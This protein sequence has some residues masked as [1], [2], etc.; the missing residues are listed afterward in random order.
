MKTYHKDLYATASITD[1]ADGTARLVV[2]TI[3]GAKI[4]DSIHKSRNA[5]YS[6]WRRMCS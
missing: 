2:R 4:K 1:R 6:S 3:C 5:A